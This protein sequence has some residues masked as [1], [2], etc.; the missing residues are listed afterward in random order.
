METNESFNEIEIESVEYVTGY[1][2]HRFSQK[3]L[4]LIGDEQGS[5]KSWI[6]H[7]SKRNLTIPSQTLIN[8]AHELEPMFK[9][10]HGNSLSNEKYIIKQ[11]SIKLQDKFQDLSLE[12]IN[13]M[14]RIRTYI[15]MNKINN[16]LLYDR[17]TIKIPN[18][19]N[20][21]VN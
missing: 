14:V 15:R 8:V 19:N 16:K 12:V 3:Y 17:N 13:Y 2:A 9:E 6:H 4:Y 11:L 5:T 21:T 20:N 1:V 10:L 7:I 18:N